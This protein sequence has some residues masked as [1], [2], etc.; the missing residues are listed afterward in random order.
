[1]FSFK[2]VMRS[3]VLAFAA[4][5]IAAAPAAADAPDITAATGSVV[6]SDATGTVIEVHGTW[7]WFTHHSDCNTDRAGVGIAIDWNDPNAAGNHVTDL[8]GESIDVGTPTD[9]H[10]YTETGALSG[11]TCGSYNGDHN[12]G[13]WGGL[14]HK[15][16]PGAIPTI[17]ALSYD[18]HGKNG[19]PS[20]TK[21][22][23]AGGANH[24][25]DNS[26][27]KNGGTPAGN[28]CADIVIPPPPP[29]P[30]C[31]ANCGPAPQLPVIAIDKSG[32]TS[33][34]AGTAVEYT[35]VVT[36]PGPTSFPASQVAVT[37]PMCSAA[38]VLVTKAGD[39][40][41]DFLNPGDSW[42][43]SCSV[44]TQLGQ[45]SVHN[46]GNV[47][48]TDTNGRPAS[49]SDTADTVLN[50]PAQGVAPLLA[51]TARLRG[52]TGCISSRTHT[53]T[54]RGTRIARVSF[55]IDG[56]YVGT[57]TRPNRGSAYT[58][59]VKGSRLR[60]GGHQVV[61]RITYRAD[62][63]PRTRTLTLA[64]ARCARAVTPKFTG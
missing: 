49:A 24:N 39:S 7:E 31:T 9:N 47:T 42:T 26:A 57:R 8:N 13:N 17:C 29:P 44:A 28:R 64:F 40:T 36:D 52:P 45:T 15:F 23:T 56:R 53:L 14:T 50:Q 19:V 35:L 62:T 1:M 54:V 34:L 30:G 38:P 3:G 20:G 27:E 10:V 37:D 58:V 51:G 32:P 46:T 18:V 4:A 60:V 59:T 21:E 5:L 11:F 48:G 33:A 41:P 16:A 2:R 6:S 22:T 61:A 63:N 43:Y 55:Y 25:S 12:S